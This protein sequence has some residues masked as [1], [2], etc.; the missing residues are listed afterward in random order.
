[1]YLDLIY[2]TWTE[3]FYQS[4][5]FY[6]S[7]HFDKTLIKVGTFGGVFIILWMKYYNNNTESSMQILLS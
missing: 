3:K 1:M 5:N 2:Y 4:A 6:Q 7:W